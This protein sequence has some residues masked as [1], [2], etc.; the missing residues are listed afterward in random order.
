MAEFM[1]R[2]TRTW[3]LAIEAEN[4]E[5]AWDKAATLTSG[6]EAPSDDCEMVI[7][8]EVPR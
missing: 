1:V 8:E 2:V 3:E 6:S 5:E 7:E 4:R